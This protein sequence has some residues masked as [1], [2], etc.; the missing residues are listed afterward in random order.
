M[1][2]CYLSLNDKV[3]V[4]KDDKVILKDNNYDIEEELFIENKIEENHILRN[5]YLGTCKYKI[6]KIRN[7][8]INLNCIL[9]LSG[10]FIS[11]SNL[12]CSIGCGVIFAA[13]NII[14]DITKK[15]IISNYQ[16]CNKMILDK[17]SK[18]SNLLM[19]IT[20]YSQK[21][22]RVCSKV[23]I[24]DNEARSRIKQLYNIKDKII[25]IKENNPNLSIE[26]IWNSSEFIDV[27]GEF[28][29][30]KKYDNN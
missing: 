12:K 29:K 14:C 13:S 22:D 30:V 15:S 26:D 5:R 16:R 7:L 21:T 28:F 9:L 25:N 11:L 10:C 20:K 23:F 4:Y 24:S 27:R 8:Q 18:D 6:K 3:F 19:D 17:I 1:N 2:Y